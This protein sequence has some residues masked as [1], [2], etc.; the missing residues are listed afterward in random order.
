MGKGAEENEPCAL[1]SDT[2]TV[3]YPLILVTGELR[4]GN[5]RDSQPMCISSDEIKDNK[6]LADGSLTIHGSAYGLENFMA[7]TS[8]GIPRAVSN[9]HHPSHGNVVNENQQ[10]NHGENVDGDNLNHQ[11]LNHMISCHNPQIG[12]SLN[13]PVSL[14][15]KTKLFVPLKCG[16]NTV[17]FQIGQ[18]RKICSM[19]VVYKP[20]ENKR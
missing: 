13:W 12:H 6:Q 15:G 20:L 9:D 3:S 7:F 4:D 19:R 18:K 14:N 11:L 8:D 17:S 2:V 10:C 1:L 16:E 5:A